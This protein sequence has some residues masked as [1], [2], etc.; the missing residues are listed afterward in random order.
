MS[1]R[2]PQIRR[3]L[4][5]SRTREYIQ[6]RCDIGGSF[7]LMKLDHVISENWEHEEIKSQV[8]GKTRSRTAYPSVTPSAHLVNDHDA[9]VLASKIVRISR[10]QPGYD[11]SAG[12]FPRRLQ[13]VPMKRKWDSRDACLGLTGTKIY[14]GGSAE[15]KRYHLSAT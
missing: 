10:G 13:R 9:S 3:T 5:C 1:L 15:F 14:F 2:R 11:E 12:E 8:L 6:F 7:N 4:R